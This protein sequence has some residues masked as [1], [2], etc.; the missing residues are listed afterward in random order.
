MDE[1]RSEQ[2]AVCMSYLK[3]ASR[4]H[5]DDE[6]KEAM[7]DFLDSQPRFFYNDAIDLQWKRRN[8]CYNVNGDVF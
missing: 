1:D 4:S 3:R 6:V 7:Q 5:L 8:L 2:C